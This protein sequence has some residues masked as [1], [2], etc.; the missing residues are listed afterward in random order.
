MVFCC[1]LQ[2]CN[3]WVRF[4]FYWDCILHF[5]LFRLI[6][7][8]RNVTWVLLSF[9]ILCILFDVIMFKRNQLKKLPIFKS[10]CVHDLTIQFKKKKVRFWNLQH[11]SS[12][13]DRCIDIF[14]ILSTENHSPSFTHT[15]QASGYLNNL[16][17]LFKYRYVNMILIY[18]SNGYLITVNCTEMK[19]VYLVFI[20]AENLLNRMLDYSINCSL[21]ITW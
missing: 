2:I 3:L 16:N 20:Y 14:L 8:T 10:I 17:V 4:E 21:Q 7:S 5:I 11:L 18:L 6:S 12:Y 1:C 13:L 19:N 9:A 15:V